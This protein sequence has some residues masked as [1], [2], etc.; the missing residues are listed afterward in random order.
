MIGIS[1][2]LLQLPFHPSLSTLPYLT[3]PIL[4]RSS[5]CCFFIFPCHAL[6]LVEEIWFRAPYYLAGICSSEDPFVLHFHVIPEDSLYTRRSI[7]AQ[8][9]FALRHHD[10]TL[11]ADKGDLSTTATAGTRYGINACLSSSTINT[12][13]EGGRHHRLITHPVST[14]YETTTS[15]STRVF[16][17]EIPL[18]AIVLDIYQILS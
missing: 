14:L 13:P 9:N 4:P 6:K 5:G 8:S 3:L 12:R 1:S 11:A 18:V 15:L 17:T 10:S 7:S 16:T 2:V